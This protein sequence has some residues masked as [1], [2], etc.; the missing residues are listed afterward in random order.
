MFK[1]DGGVIE[2]SILKQLKRRVGKGI[3]KLFAGGR[4]L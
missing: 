4:G 1:W 2:E 3:F